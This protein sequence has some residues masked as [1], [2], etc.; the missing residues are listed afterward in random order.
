[1]ASLLQPE[2]FEVDYFIHIFYKE[3]LRIRFI[4]VTNITFGVGETNLLFVTYRGEANIKILHVNQQ[5]IVP[6][7]APYKS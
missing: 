7:Y 2:H 1:M 5:V 4:N 3:D 6:N